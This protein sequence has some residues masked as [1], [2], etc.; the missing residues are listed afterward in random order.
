[1]I[2]GTE[3]TSWESRGARNTL[4]VVLS[5][6]EQN[7][8]LRSWLDC[9]LERFGVAGNHGLDQDKCLKRDGR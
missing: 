8:F 7:S 2:R 6:D 1:M 4:K 3:Y 5:S 9:A